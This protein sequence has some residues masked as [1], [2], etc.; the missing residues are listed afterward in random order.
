MSDTSPNPPETSTA[1]ENTTGLNPAEMQPQKAAQTAAEPEKSS[2]GPMRNRPI[3]FL[4]LETTGLNPGYQEI[5]EIGAVLVSQPDWQVITT[6][7]AKV[8]PSHLETAQPEALLIGHFDAAVWEK[9]GR[10]LKQAL[11]ELSEIGQG[12]ILA[13]FNV[14]FDWAFLQTGFNLVDLPDPFYYHRYD[15]M[16]AAFSM[17]YDRAEFKK[18]SLSECCR[19]FGV[20]NTKAHSALADAQATYEVF[21]GLMQSANS[22]NNTTTAAPAV[23]PAD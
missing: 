11:E 1:P 6:Y 23:K 4:D 21:V 17:L 14:T 8:L 10:P 5:S 9:E 15:V 22:T 20:T 13:G 2:K 12:A 16:S 18:F 19:Y 3:L 7:E